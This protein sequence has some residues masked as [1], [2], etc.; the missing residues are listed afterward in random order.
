MDV[1]TDITPF[2]GPS[3]T[4][5]DNT[6]LHPSKKCT[7]PLGPHFSKEATTATALP[8][9]KSASLVAVGPLC[10]DNKIVIF[11]KN[12]VQAVIPNEK[13]KTA[14]NQSNVVLQGHRN[15]NDGCWDINLDKT[16]VSEAS[17]KYPATHSGL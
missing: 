1:C 4:L 7:I 6:S 13:L 10:D 2:Q 12:A 5:P 3:V 16:T 8:H 14:I 15:M 17:V 9:L 11:D